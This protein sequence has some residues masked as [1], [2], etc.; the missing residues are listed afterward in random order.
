MVSIKSISS[1]NFY[2]NNPQSTHF[3]LKPLK[4]YWQFC[5][6]GLLHGS[7][8]VHLKCQKI[9]LDLIKILGRVEELDLSF[10]NN[11]KWVKS[12]KKQ[13]VLLKTL[14]YVFHS[15]R[16]DGQAWNLDKKIKQGGLVI[17]LVMV[18]FNRNGGLD[19]K[20]FEL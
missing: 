10:Q 7:K 11:R 8:L 16:V 20:H 3:G 12:L 15:V 17:I 18:T 9:L 14:I 5:C 6:S 4:K 13:M 19:Q 2:F 1:C